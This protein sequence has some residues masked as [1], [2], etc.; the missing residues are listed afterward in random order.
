MQLA[1]PPSREGV[2]LKEMRNPAA[3]PVRRGQRITDGDG[4]SLEEVDAMTVSSQG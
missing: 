2:C 1:A 4:I 3:G